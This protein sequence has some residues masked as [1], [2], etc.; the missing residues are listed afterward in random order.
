MSDLE[1]VKNEIKILKKLIS[2]EDA[3]YYTA[4]MSALSTVEGII[5]TVEGEKNDADA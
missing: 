4:Y 1:R 2:A 5:A 3:A